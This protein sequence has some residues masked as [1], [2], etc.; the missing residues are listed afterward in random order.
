MIGA[1]IFSVNDNVHPSYCLDSLGSL[2]RCDESGPEEGLVP[3][4]VQLV[5]TAEELANPFPWTLTISAVLER[6]TFVARTQD[7]VKRA[8]RGLQLA[9]TTSPFVPHIHVS[10]SEDVVIQAI[11]LM[12]SLTAADALAVREQLAA[13]G[14][15]EIP[16]CTNFNASFH[17]ATGAGL[18]V[19][20]IEYVTSGWMSSMKVYRKALVRSA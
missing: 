10:E 15:F 18:T 7:D 5:S 11:D 20:P 3:F 6:L 17:E 1:V 8:Y 14:V 13:T 16:V 9:S 19:P 4:G 2:I 12:P